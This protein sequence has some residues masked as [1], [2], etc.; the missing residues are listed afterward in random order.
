[1]K[2]VRQIVTSDKDR[3]F[4]GST[5][6]DTDDQAFGWHDNVNAGIM[7]SEMEQHSPKLNINI[8]EEDEYSGDGFAHPTIVES[9]LPAPVQQVR[10]RTRVACA[11]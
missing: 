8:P 9:T 5:G 7:T 6:T 11:A 2:C 1:M 4:S 3:A 10:E